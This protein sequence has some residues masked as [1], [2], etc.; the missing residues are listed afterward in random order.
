MLLC[1]FIKILDAHSMES[2]DDEARRVIKKSEV[3]QKKVTWLNSGDFASAQNI[4]K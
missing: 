1:A 3:K 2:Y 4:E